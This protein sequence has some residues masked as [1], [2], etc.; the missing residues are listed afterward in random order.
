MKKLLFIAKFIPAPD[1]NGG[2][3]RN[4]AW[5]RF[6]SNYFDLIVVG[7][8]DK[9][10]GNNRVH[11]LEKYVSKIEG[12][13]FSRTKL[14]LA[15]L[16]MR[17]LIQNSSI[18]LKQYHSPVLSQK[19]S[20]LLSNEEIDCIFCAELSSTQYIP[21]ECKIPI[22]FDDH[23][24][25]Y[26]LVARNAS[27]TLYPLKFF[28][29][30]EAF[31]LKKYEEKI[32][33]DVDMISF[34]SQR[35]ELICKNT[36][37][38]ACS[39]VVENTYNN[40]FISISDEWFENPTL[41]FVGNI[42]WKPNRQGLKHFLISIY[43]RIKKK[44][45]SVKL[46]I[47]GSGMTKSLQKL[48]NDGSIIILENIEEEKKRKLISMSWLCIVPV[49][50]GSGTRIKILEYWA[51]GKT[52]VATTIGAEGLDISQG[53]K[54]TDTDEG[55]FEATVDALSDKNKLFLQGMENKKLFETKY[56]E[57]RV[58]ENTL[59][60]TIAAKCFRENKN[61]EHIKDI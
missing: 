47:I 56:E 17:S 51:N 2:A 11:E 16:C 45:S 33:D 9:K 12:V 40:E 57:S 36:T 32:W 31:L 4:R 46:Y 59:Y 19:I 10:Y 37:P 29:E 23:N 41:L 18:L 21:Q 54:I 44:V 48:C 50:W 43:P 22:I 26:E 58:Y 61:S 42:S 15:K 7:F 49:Y 8:W 5:I 3:K 34:V 39:C 60:N 13:N 20:S 25:E 1:F 30:R 24:I 53:T 52:V 38:N 14:S 27:K 35:D 6:L 28:Y 55:F